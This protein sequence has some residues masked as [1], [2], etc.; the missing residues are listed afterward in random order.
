MDYDVVI[1]GGGFAGAYCA[2]ALCKAMGADSTRRV[3]LIAER[4]VLVF[5]PMLAEVCGSSLSPIDVVNP[6][7]LFCRKATVLQGQIQRVDWE[8]KSLVLDGG[9]FSR[10]HEI[11]FKHLVV[12]MGSV[13][14]LKQV[15]GMAEYGWPMK[16]MADALRLRS[17]IINRLEEANLIED[18]AVRSRLLSFVVI[19]G[20][21]TGVEVAGQLFDL[22]TDSQ[23]YYSNLREAKVR[24][25]LVHSGGQLMQ[26]IGAELG[27]YAL[28]ELQKRGIEVRLHARVVEVSA[29]RVRM[30]QGEPIEANTIVSTI[31]TAPNP[32]VVDLAKQLKIE[33]QKGRIA[34]APSLNVEGF[35]G[36]WAIGD[37][38]SV[39]W[40]DRGTVKTAPPTAQLAVRQG[41]QLGGN[42]HRALTGRPLQ[43]FTYRYMGQLAAIGNKRAVAEVFG[44][45]FK[46]FFAW[47]MW[48]TI[49]L[50][51]LPGIARRIRVVIDWTFEL[52]FP[53]D[54][55]ILLPPPDDALRAIHLEKD[56]VL[57]LDKERSR[58]F[59]YI[60]HGTIAVS[61]GSGEPRL[62]GA[63]TVI[64]SD[65]T[66]H[67]GHWVVRAVASESSD[68]VVIRGRARDLLVSE[69][70]LVPRDQPPGGR[71]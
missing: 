57:F 43:P 69:L 31:G 37:C 6:L 22:I 3:A 36:L 29:N 42:L 64:D 12:A 9:R 14:D 4:N 24:V 40:N 1:A 19:G 28:E 70:R 59:F 11:S 68:V 67:E 65:Y 26:E 54:I 56:E 10:N 63:G 39:P 8:T 53:R 23:K 2:R 55:S 33:L 17:A 38:A 27:E 25:S 34:V 50:A 41:T 52:I 49:Y 66:D 5:Q 62:L 13:T 18:P 51:K 32:I 21:Y 60:R 15:P 71:S 45:H 35:D 48:R 61:G 7:R 44:L 20:G 47:W 16:T 30:D 58:A 46:G